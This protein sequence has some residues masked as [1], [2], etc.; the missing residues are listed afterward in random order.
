MS[1]IFLLNCVFVAFYGVL[2]IKSIILKSKLTKNMILEA[3]IGISSQ[4]FELQYR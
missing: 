2:M 1:Q 4:I 3:R